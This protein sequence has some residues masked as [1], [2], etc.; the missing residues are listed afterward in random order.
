MD[1]VARTASLAQGY[2]M[3]GTAQRYQQKIEQSLRVKMSSYLI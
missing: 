1:A 2:A 3:M